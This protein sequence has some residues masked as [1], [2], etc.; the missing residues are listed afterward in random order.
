MQ[1][2][3]KNLCNSWLIRNEASVHRIRNRE[4]AQW[5]TREVAIYTV[6]QKDDEKTHY[7]NKW[8]QY[9]T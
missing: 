2:E 4:R 6:Y 9:M 8:T 5:F 7:S 1:K 3:I